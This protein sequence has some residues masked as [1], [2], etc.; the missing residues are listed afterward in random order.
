MSEPKKYVGKGKV[1]G[2]YGVINI[3]LRYEDLKPN[4]L[5]YVNICI[6]KMKNADN[7]GNTHTA[8]LNDYQPK[9][10]ENKPEIISQQS[11]DYHAV[12]VPQTDDLPF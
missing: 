1:V 2:Q 4:E 3:G 12:E 11:T 10:E 7:N 6:G 5:G 8:W 9:H